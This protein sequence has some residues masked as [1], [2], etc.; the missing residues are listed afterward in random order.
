M[1]GI[2]VKSKDAPDE[3]RPFG[4]KGEGRVVNVG[5]RIVL[6]GTFEPGWRWS[7]NIKPVAGTDSCEATHVMYCISGRMG[8]AHNDGTQ[9]EVGPGDIAVIEPG[10]DAWVIGDEQFVSV[11]FGGYAAYAKPQA[12]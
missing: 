6:Y 3:T 5:D 8:V 4:G 9:A 11:D 7:D 1:A 10:H 12:S 2:E